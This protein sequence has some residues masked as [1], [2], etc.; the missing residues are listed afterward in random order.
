MKKFLFVLLMF[1][2]LTCFSGLPKK[3][4]E[5]LELFAHVL[6]MIRQNFVGNIEHRKLIYGA[7]KGMLE[8]LDP[9]SHHYPPEAYREMKQDTSGAFGGI[10]I[11]ITTRDKELTIVAPIEGSP[12]HRAG[13]EPG[14][15]IVKIGESF[16]KDLT[17]Y[18]CMKLLKGKIRTMVTIFVKRRDRKD[19]LK[20]TMRRQRIRE[21]S[22]TMKNLGKITGPLLALVEHAA[23]RNAILTWPNSD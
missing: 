16:T 4:Y 21:K 1:F 10:G 8:D 13:I 17:M 15:K 19:L 5:D 11:E 22:V 2:T 14:D 12:A 18:K 6:N 7:I 9:H 23:P 20:F 3:E